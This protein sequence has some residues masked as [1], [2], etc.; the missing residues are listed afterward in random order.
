[1][2][3]QYLQ[4]LIYNHHCVC[5]RRYRYFFLVT[6]SRS[7]F[8]SN[9]SIPFRRLRF[10]FLILQLTFLSSVFWSD[11]R[12]SSTVTYLH[13]PK[14]PFERSRHGLSESMFGVCIR[15]VGIEL[16]VPEIFIISLG[17]RFLVNGL[18]VS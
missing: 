17:R 6:H 1:M 18:V 9:I 12:Y 7:Y 14:P 15:W 2:S 8:N 10:H 16:W 5:Y 3:G 13:A 4:V 11:G